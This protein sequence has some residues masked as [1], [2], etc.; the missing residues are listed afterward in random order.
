MEQLK[1]HCY[2]NIRKMASPSLSTGKSWFKYFRYVEGRDSPSD[3][4][5]VLLVVAD[6]IAAVTFQAGV[7][8]PGRVWQDNEDGQRRNRGGGWPCP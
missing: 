1:E 5:N 7:N 6:L 3:A 4:R 2:C 8:P